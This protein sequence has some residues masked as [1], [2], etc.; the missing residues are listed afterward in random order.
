MHEI[1]EVLSETLIPPQN[2]TLEITESFMMEDAEATI[3]TFQRLKSLGVRIAIDDFGTGYSALSYLRRFPVDVL[4][5]DKEFVDEVTGG[6]E[7]SALVQAIIR[8]GASFG[9]E[10]V[11]EGIENAEQVSSLQTLG[12]HVGQGFF[13]ARP[14]TPEKVDEI[15]ADGEALRDKVTAGTET[16]SV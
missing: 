15:L 8:L 3:E 2:L 14:T 4:K 16:V 10:T 1:S 5:I 6:V 11:A 9:L 13:L 7:Q 12:C